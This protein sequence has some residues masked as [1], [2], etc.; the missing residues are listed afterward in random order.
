MASYRGMK[1]NQNFLCFL[2]LLKE[3]SIYLLNKSIISLHVP[4]ANCN[5]ICVIYKKK[6]QYLTSCETI[7]QMHRETLIFTKIFCKVQMLSFSLSLSSP[8]T[9]SYIFYNKL[10][11]K[12]KSL[13]RLFSITKKQD[14]N[15]I[16]SE[17][18]EKI[19]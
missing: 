15:I 12:F 5:N 4:F 3:L 2:R 1:N 8:L 17:I 7:I 14:R 18:H 9:F 16:Y 10:E 19:L 6:K 11:I 13:R